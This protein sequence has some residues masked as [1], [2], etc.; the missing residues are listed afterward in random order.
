[1]KWIFKQYKGPPYV[2]IIKVKGEKKNRR[3]VAFDKE[4]ISNQLHGKEFKVL[5]RTDD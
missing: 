3:M 4:H 5:R 1:M 2:F